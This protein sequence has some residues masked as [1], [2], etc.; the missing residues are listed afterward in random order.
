MTRLRQKA[1]KLLIFKLIIILERQRWRHGEIKR[2]PLRLDKVNSFSGSDHPPRWLE[3]KGASKLV[4][5][6]FK[7]VEIKHSKTKPN[8]QGIV[9]FLS[10]SYMKMEIIKILLTVNWK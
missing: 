8:V 6:L 4:F 9:K 2:A 1:A 5:F 10:N 7:V 3:L